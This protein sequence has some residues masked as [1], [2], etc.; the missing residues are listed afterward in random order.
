MRKKI[1]TKKI[2]LFSLSIM[3]A[4]GF[5][6]CGKVTNEKK[7]VKETKKI[8][9]LVDGTLYVLHE[10]VYLPAYNR[11]NTFEDEIS[12]T[13]K[14]NRIIWFSTQEEKDK[15]IPTLYEGDKLVLCTKDVMPDYITWERFFDGG[16]SF[17]IYGLEPD[18]SNKYRLNINQGKGIISA[19]NNIPISGNSSA[20]KLTELSNDND[21]IIIDSIG[22]AKLN[23]DSLTEAGTIKNLEKGKTY[24]VDVY[25]GTYLHEY[26][27]KADTRIFYSTEVY[28]KYDYNFLQSNIAELTLPENLLTGYYYIEGYGFIRYVK[29]KSYDE[30]TDFNIKQKETNDTEGPSSVFDYLDDNTDDDDYIYID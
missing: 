26:K 13:P 8:E 5:C 27:L 23:S 12:D 22:D 4:I 29:G 2:L 18:D 21:S 17:G 24:K 19:S 30:N 6:G 28:K 14:L 10:G 9:D 15:P 1:F 11:E 3:M 20:D 16:T 7:E 25:S